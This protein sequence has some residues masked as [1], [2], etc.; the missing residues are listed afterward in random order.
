[1]L[2]NYIK[3]QEAH[4]AIA[5]VRDQQGALHT[6][7]SDINNNFK[8]FYENLYKSELVAGKTEIETFLCNLDLPTLSTE[9]KHLLD[10]PITAEEIVGII[11]TL[12]VGKAPG[13]D[14]FTADFDSAL[15]VTL[16]H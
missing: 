3:Q 15:L 16:L 11:Q 6:S 1:M 5:A 10:A 13:P 7:T 8:E 2:A 12:P 14:G 4:S 9:Q